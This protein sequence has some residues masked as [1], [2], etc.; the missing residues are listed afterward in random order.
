MPRGE[1][2]MSSQVVS[3]FHPD[4]STATFP[5]FNPTTMECLSKLTP[6]TLHQSSKAHLTACVF[7]LLTQTR[8]A[9]A[10]SRRLTTK[11]PSEGTPCTSPWSAPQTRAL[12]SGA[13]G[14]TKRAGII[15]RRPRPATDSRFLWSKLSAVTFW[16]ARRACGSA[17]A[18]AGRY[19][20]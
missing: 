10:V 2:C 6:L 19:F 3:T 17:S 16:Q 9:W 14:K 4:K 5:N 1:S 11:H 18:R 12:L 8:G 15:R 13:G 7:Q 20:F